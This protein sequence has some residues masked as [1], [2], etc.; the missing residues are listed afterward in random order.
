MLKVK[1]SE[2]SQLCP[3]LCNPMD[4]SL[5]GSSAHGISQARV[6][7]WVA[8]SFSRGSS[9]PRDWTLVSHIVGR[10]FTAS[11][12]REVL[13]MLRHIYIYPQ[14]YISTHIV[15]SISI[16]VESCYHKW[17]LIC[18]MLFLHLW[19]WLY[20]FYSSFC[21]DV[22]HWLI[23]GK[24]PLD[25]FSV[26]LNLVCKH[27]VEDFCIYVHQEYW[28]VSFL[29]VSHSGFGIRIILVS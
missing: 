24:I 23:C 22:S 18:Q 4:Y 11:T 25:L 7:Q 21:C 3:T 19:R 20:D 8:I 28:A 9:Q 26:L 14:I 27:F 2:V 17:M 1:E 5:P 13:I 10:R 15:S 6:L 29:L 12:T 16:F